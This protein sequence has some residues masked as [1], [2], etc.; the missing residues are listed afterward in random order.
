ME[1][2]EVMRTSAAIRE[3]SESQ[4]PESVL[5]EI[6]DA[7]RFAPSG[8]NR[9]P[10]RVVILKDQSIR[11]D[12]ARLYRE[13]WKEYMAHVE[14]GMVPFAPINAGKWEGSAVD[15]A[16]AQSREFPN[17]FAD[18]LSDAPVLMIIL[19]KLDALAVL[20]NGLD[21]QSIV[22][23]GSVYPFGHNILLAARD[24][25]LGGVMTTVICRR[26]PE[27]KE[28]LCVPDG[29]AVAALVVLG[30]PRKFLTKLSRRKVEEFAVI[31][32]FSGESFEPTRR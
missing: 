21:R 9:Q 2:S 27:V 13:G 12:L 11:R 14:K 10:W 4:V 5:Y 28:L 30:V 6:L 32:R 26:E 23:G 29:F 25:G 24:K 8:G 16:E 15:L 20:D 7:A 18:Q 19:A 1:L 3:F 22:G 17:K 31:D